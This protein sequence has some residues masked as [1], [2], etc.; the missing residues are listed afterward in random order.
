MPQERHNPFPYPTAAEVEQAPGSREEKAARNVV[1]RHIPGLAR[2]DYLLGNNDHAPILAGIRD[3]TGAC[4][5]LLDALYTDS[6]IMELPPQVDAL[7]EML[8]QHGCP[9]AVEQPEEVPQE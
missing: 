4:Y 1:V 3:L 5:A 7:R 2:R 9:E 6:T 8:E